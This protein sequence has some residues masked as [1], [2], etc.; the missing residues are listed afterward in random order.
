MKIVFYNLQSQE[1]FANTMKSYITRQSKTPG[2]KYSYLFNDFYDL[3]DEVCI[4]TGNNFLSSM[5][6]FNFKE[7]KKEVSDCLLDTSKYL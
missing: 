2:G 4:Y 3:F 5:N 7:G 1:I 6:S